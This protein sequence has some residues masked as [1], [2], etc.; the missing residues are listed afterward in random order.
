MRY[1]WHTGSLVWLLHRITGVLL[2]FY[3]IAHIFVLSH[4]RNPE[5]YNKI[6]ALMKNPFIKFA[7]LILF[8]VILIHV[9]AGIRITLLEMGVSTKYQ[10]SMAYFSAFLVGLVWIVGAFYFLREVF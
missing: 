5:E 1:K 6:M 2:T 9:F 4:L 3:L 7:E 8:A 10:K